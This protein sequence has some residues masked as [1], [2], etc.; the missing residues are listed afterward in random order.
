MLLHRC[1]VYFMVP[2]R[3]ECRGE[4]VTL[5]SKCFGLYTSLNLSLLETN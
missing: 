1:V 5:F 3:K 4:L 2:V